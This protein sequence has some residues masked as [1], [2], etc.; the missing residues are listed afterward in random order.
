MKK[1]EEEKQEEEEQGQKQK[2]KKGLRLLTRLKAWHRWFHRRQ[3]QPVAPVQ[4]DETEHECV[5]CHYKYKG[6]LCPQCG[7]SSTLNRFTLKRLL[8]NFL[9]IWG[10]GSRPMF[11][12]MLDLLWRPGY[13]IRDYLRGHHL[14]YFPPFKMLIV[15]IFLTAILMWL[16][17]IEATTPLNAEAF[18]KMQE[19]NPNLVIPPLFIE[20]ID[21]LTK[22]TFY[23]LLAQN[24]IL[25]VV[26]WLVFR[27]RGLNIVE[28]FFSQIYINNQ[29]Q[30]LTIVWICLTQTWESSLLFPYSIPYFIV[31]PVLVYDF[32]QLYGVSI[33][34]ALWKY[35]V[36]LILMALF[37]FILILA[38][39]IIFLA[40]GTGL[41]TLIVDG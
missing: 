7:M 30:L 32:H 28:T 24:V 19:K 38:L 8:T 5:H 20:A 31:L 36:I 12:S 14:S 15:L 40:M 9:D 2:K 4:W 18:Q 13:M 34:K 22:N 41:K 16:F 37:Y 33:W 27:K 35:F 25:V 6:R 29:M 3:E 26:V 1:Q 10:L 21:F 39:T 17:G 23:R 11:Q